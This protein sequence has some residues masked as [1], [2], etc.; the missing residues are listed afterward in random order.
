MH[1]AWHTP[2][3]GIV[4]R[5]AG[6]IA[7]STAGSG[8]TRAEGG[9]ALARSAGR[10]DATPAPEEGRLLTRPSAP[11]QAISPGLHWLGLDPDRDALLYVPRGYRPERPAPL[12]LS[13]H[14]AGGNA[15]AGLYPLHNLADGGGLLLLAPASRGRTWDMILGGYGPDIAFID[16]ALATT[17]ARVAV[18]PAR[19]AIGGFSDGAS[20]ALSLGIANGDLFRHV[21]AFSPGFASP[22]G[23]RGRPRVFVSHGT[24]DEVLA[25]DRT[26]RRI[27]PRLEEAGY[28]VRYREFDGPHTVP[29]QVAQESVAWLLSAEATGPE[30]TPRDAPPAPA[31][32][33]AIGGGTGAGR[34]LYT[35][36]DSILDAG[37]YN[38]FRTD[39]GRLLVGNDDRLFPEFRGRDL[40][41]YGPARLAHR[42]VDG[43]TV[44]DLP[45]Q[46]RG[47]RPT[48]PSVAILTVGGND[49]LRGLLGDDGPGIDA[50]AD[51]LDTFLRALPVWPVCLGNVYD[52]T[53][54][55]DA[56]NFTGVTPGRAR[57]N[58]RRVN[59]VIAEAAARHGV[60]VDL[61]A[62]FLS[63]DPSWYA[64]T[65]EPSLRGTSEIRRCFLPHVLAA[66][67]LP[68]G[69]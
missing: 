29:Q 19:L 53:F 62:H 13:L 1:D 48:G 60:L 54:G 63:G 34:T 42:A 8:G 15:E 30:T 32:K 65:I 9:T 56:A 38:E 51:A 41:S 67:D 68:E 12:V 39:P 18:D 27:V 11:T 31:P 58:H 24:R 37:W 55:D 40:S 2:R 61:H 66:F 17:F 49:L 5:V 26:S 59:A 69:L 21:L 44:R 7:A 22:P 16:S 3:R 57:Q 14:G 50:F 47:L 6:I 43:A 4:A 10:G 28:D 45:A 46:A 64:H 35:F 25:I 23:Q 36:G 52:P 33:A 20:Y